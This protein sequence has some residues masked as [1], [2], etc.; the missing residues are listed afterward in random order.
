MTGAKGPERRAPRPEDLPR[1]GGTG[2][3][4]SRM[5][6][7]TPSD[8]VPD[9][10][11]ALPSSGEPAER[12][13]D[14]SPPLLVAARQRRDAAPAHEC[15]HRGGPCPGCSVHSGRAVRPHL[16]T[17]HAHAWHA[18][19][20]ARTRTTARVRVATT[21]DTTTTR[22]PPVPRTRTH[23]TRAQQAGRA[24]QRKPD[25]TGPARRRAHP[26][27]GSRPPR[28]PP[29]TPPP[30]PPAPPRGSMGTTPR[31]ASNSLTSLRKDKSD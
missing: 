3:G 12:D 31:R 9:N 16:P 11:Q 8:E 14:P 15:G 6:R 5:S 13:T 19:R 18:A 23:T 29:P 24:E 2:W 22:C 4:C 1:G 25:A 17:P 26:T 7:A 27:P 30:P 28:A 20:T 10:L 21:R